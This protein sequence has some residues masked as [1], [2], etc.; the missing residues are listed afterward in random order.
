MKIGL[1]RKI[2]VFAV[3]ILI[4]TVSIA[5]MAGG[6]I[7]K[8]P[9]G[10]DDR[11]LD[12][13]QQIEKNVRAKQWKEAKDNADSATEAWKKIVN[14][15]QFSVERDYMFEINGALAR[16]KG[17]IEAKDDKAIM[18]EIYFFYDLFDGLGG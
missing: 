7:L 16:I 14:R 10:K 17:G 13:V 1:I 6:S 15:I 2:M 12:A 9:W 5:V 3:P 11:V 4:L 18:E 8:K